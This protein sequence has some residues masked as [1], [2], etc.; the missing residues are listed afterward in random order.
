MVSSFL[1]CFS[2]LPP[3]GICRDEIAGMR[4][5]DEAIYYSFAMNF[6]NVPYVGSQTLWG[7]GS[8][9]TKSGAKAV[10]PSTAERAYVPQQTSPLL[11]PS[12]TGVGWDATVPRRAQ[13]RPLVAYGQFVA[14]GVRHLHP[15]NYPSQSSHSA[16]AS[17]TSAV[18]NPSVNQ[19]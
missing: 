2:S 14:V 18:S 13:R 8:V 10:G 17:C 12:E 9:Q 6:N 11:V 19:P 16:L 3:R 7:S 1:L 5:P 15:S 4:H